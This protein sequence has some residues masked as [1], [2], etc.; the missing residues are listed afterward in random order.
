MSSTV[1]DINPALPI[2]GVLLVGS[3]DFNFWGFYM[4]SNKSAK[5]LTFRRG[6]GVSQGTVDDINPAL[7]IIRNIP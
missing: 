6:S 5:S 1:D 7:P 2:L 4:N 3:W